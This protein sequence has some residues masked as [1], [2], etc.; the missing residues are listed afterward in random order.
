MVNHRSR[1]LAA[2][3]AAAGAL[4][5]VSASAATAAPA[6]PAAGGARITRV[7]QQPDSGLSP[8][9]LVM[10]KTKGCQNGPIQP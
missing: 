7:G 2:V 6:S 10:P 1:T 8:L 4:T 3:V 5:L 9:C